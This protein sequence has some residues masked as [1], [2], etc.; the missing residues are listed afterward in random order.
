MASRPGN[1]IVTGIT[2]VAE[3]GKPVKLTNVAPST[4]TPVTLGVLVQC[5]PSNTGAQCVIGDKN[6][7]AEKTLGKTRGI[8]LEKKAL[9]VRIEISDPTQLWIDAEKSKDFVLWTVIV[10]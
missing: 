4:I 1:Q 7:V 2:E 5:D 3:T 10:G 8:V 9:P 6:V